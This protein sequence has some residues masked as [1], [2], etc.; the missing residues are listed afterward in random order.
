M[1]LQIVHLLHV[2]Q[3]QEE[4]SVPCLA[5]HCCVKSSILNGLTECRVSL[6]RGT[7]HI[8]SHE[9]LGAIPSEG[10]FVLMKAPRTDAVRAFAPQLGMK[11]IKH[12]RNRIC[13]VVATARIFII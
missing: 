6:Q 3:V 5:L 13:N 11:I 12:H 1:V 8:F 10:A 7:A 4:P 9:D 2:L